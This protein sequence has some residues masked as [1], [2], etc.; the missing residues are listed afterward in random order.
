MNG[1]SGD[2]DARDLMREI[3]SRHPG[4]REALLADL[5][6]TMVH[7]GEFR[8][9]NS[10]A[11]ALLQLCRMMWVTDGFLAQALYR[12]KAALQRLGV[13]LLPRLAHHLALVTGQVSIGDPVVIHPGICLLHGQVVIDGIVEIHSGVVIAPF[14]T[15]GL[16]P[17][18]VVGP[19][20]EQRVR[21]G[22][23]AKVLGN[24]H[25]GAGAAIGANAVVFDDVPEETTVVGAPARPVPEP[26]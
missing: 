23:G 13:P 12:L 24:V 1:P 25:V 17:N 14:V 4:L 16:Q 7:R 19:T 21:I 3:R 15:V 20:I 22:T 6:L 11:D 2:P 5:K 18:D 10:R 9:I 8:E 26:V